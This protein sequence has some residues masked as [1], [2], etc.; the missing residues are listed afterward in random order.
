MSDVNCLP[1]MK[2]Q[3]TIKFWIQR[4]ESHLGWPGHL[5]AGLAWLPYSW[6]V[7][8]TLQLG[9]PGLL[10]AGLAWTSYI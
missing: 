4:E 1:G 6:V 2:L 8:A 7:L 5:T 9:C 3:T 10:T